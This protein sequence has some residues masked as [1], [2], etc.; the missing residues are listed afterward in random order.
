M[1]EAQL[2]GPGIVDRYERVTSIMKDWEAGY[3]ALG[4]YYDGLLK[5][6]PKVCNFINVCFLNI[7][8]V[9]E[10]CVPVFVQVSSRVALWRINQ[11]ACLRLNMLSHA[12]SGKRCFA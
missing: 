3:Y 11:L 12:D 4:R 9:L 7:I 6:L 10:N 5:A 8:Y 2:D 1:F